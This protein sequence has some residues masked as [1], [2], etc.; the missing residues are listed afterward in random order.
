[1]Y[2]I[3]FFVYSI[4]SA[5]N[6][7]LNIKPSALRF[8]I[9]FLFFIASSSASATPKGSLCKSF[10]INSSPKE[11]IT[12]G[13]SRRRPES[14]YRGSII[15]STLCV[16]RDEDLVEFSILLDFRDI[17]GKISRGERDDVLTSGFLSVDSFLST[18]NNKFKINKSNC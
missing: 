3:L 11:T 12:L 15:S 5:R 2:F 10:L 18:I 17:G 7:S 6:Y 8:S 16:L 13:S 4:I 14:R 9:S 1:M